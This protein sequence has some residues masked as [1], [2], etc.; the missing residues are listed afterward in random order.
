MM[1]LEIHTEYQ[2][3]NSTSIMICTHYRL[4]I[5][6]ISLNSTQGIVQV[7]DMECKFDE[8]L[9]CVDIYFY[10]QRDSCTCKYEHMRAN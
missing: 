5:I 8:E 10:T 3:L 7:R 2:K 1:I 9:F 4:Y 6:I